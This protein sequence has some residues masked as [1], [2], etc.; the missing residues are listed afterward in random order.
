MERRLR[1]GG[2]QRARRQRRGPRRRRGVRVSV[3]R[4]CCCAL[5]RWW[6]QGC[7]R[8]EQN[9]Q[10]QLLLMTTSLLHKTLHV[11]VQYRTDMVIICTMHGGQQSNK[12]AHDTRLAACN[13]NPHVAQ[14]CL[15]ARPPETLACCLL[16]GPRSSRSG[17]HRSRSWS[18][19]ARQSAHFLHALPSPPAA[20]ISCSSTAPPCYPLLTALPDPPA[21][22]PSCTL[23]T[24]PSCYHS[25]IAMS[26][27]DHMRRP[28]RAAEALKR[29]NEI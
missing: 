23:P 28:F 19:P 25:S 11:A 27:R 6:R 14:M 9:A 29:L 4:A 24:A 8:I 1:E 3:H 22:F 7:Q 17:R 2:R 26:P 5:A 10:L 15:L 13:A 18:V 20:F 16:Q 12:P 21:D